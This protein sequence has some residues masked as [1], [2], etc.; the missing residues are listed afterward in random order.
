VQATGRNDECKVNEKMAGKKLNSCEQRFTVVIKNGGKA[1]PARLLA[2]PL[3]VLA[4]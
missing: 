3:T 1:C 2:K 4:L